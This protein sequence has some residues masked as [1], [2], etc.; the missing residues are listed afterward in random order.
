MTIINLRDGM[1]SSAESFDNAVG[2]TRHK[3]KK[4]GLGKLI[5]ESQSAQRERK[6]IRTKSKAGARLGRADAKNKDA[7]AKQ[8]QANAAKEGVKGDI[9]LGNALAV[10]APGADTSSSSMSPT[11]KYVLIGL[12]A[13]VVVGGGGFAIYKMTKK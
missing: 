1:V 13:L 9:A 12:A 7:I 3:A 11:V 10:S 6:M 4:A 8:L 2:R 5:K